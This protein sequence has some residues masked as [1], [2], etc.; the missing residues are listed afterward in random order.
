MGVHLNDLRKGGPGAAKKNLLA[1]QGGMADPTPP[2][3]FSVV[4]LELLGTPEARKKAGWLPA[5]CW[6]SFSY[7]RRALCLQNGQVWTAVW[8]YM[9][10]CR[11][12]F[13]LAWKHGRVHVSYVFAFK[14]Y[15][16]RGT[17]SVEHLSGGCSGSRYRA[18]VGWRTPRL[19]RRCSRGGGR[20]PLGRLFAITDETIL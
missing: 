6:A 13:V 1:K 2:P 5:G 12:D 18:P 15:G 10:K 16:R 11:G 9:C 20:T 4:S 8:I 19:Q 3:S 7:G 14:K 17:A